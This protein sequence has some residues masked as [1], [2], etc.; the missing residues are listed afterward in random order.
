[1]PKHEINGSWYST[2]Q[3]SEMSGIPQHTIRDRLRRGYEIEE[4]IK[5]LPI[6]KSVKDFSEASYYMDWVGETIDE[7]WSIYWKWSLD[8]GYSPLQKQGFSRQ[9]MGM[10]PML[11]TVPSQV[12]NGY[13]R[14][15]RLKKGC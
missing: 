2:K 13:K 1:M 14:I 11:K 5:V 3:L 7:V 8:N 9:V 12:G 10:Y 4:A 6:H 15:I